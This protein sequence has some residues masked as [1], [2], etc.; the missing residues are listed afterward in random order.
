MSHYK[1]IFFD[2]DRTL[3]DF[4]TNTLKTFRDIYEKYDLTKYFTDYHSFHKSYTE[5]NQ[6]LW[7]QYLD[8]KLKK[9]TLRT[10]RFQLTL[11]KNGLDNIVLAEKIGLDYITLS[12]HK[13]VLFPYTLET[14]QYLKNKY[15]LHIITNGFNEVQFVKIKNCGLE[16]FFA[17]VVTS[18]K[19]GYQ[20][21]RKEIFEYSL[22]SVN[23]KKNESIMVGDDFEIDIIGAKNAGI[24]QVYFN[25]SR[26]AQ[27][28]KATFEIYSLKELQ[29][30]L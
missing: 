9:E 16:P 8:G 12:P 1:H 19:A 2:L 26:I 27:E 30:I 20:K 13:T 11:E 10:L 21:P 3:W 6:V 29:K 28:E 14:L 22:K 4:E 23:A 25:P 17:S 7:Q 5:I 15:Q 24:D 18:E